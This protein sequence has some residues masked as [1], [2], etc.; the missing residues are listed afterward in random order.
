MYAAAVNGKCTH[1]T[2]LILD[3]PF[4]LREGG[5]GY[6]NIWV[7]IISRDLLFD[8]KESEATPKV[9]ASVLFMQDISVL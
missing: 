7:E 9:S 3:L 1:L 4:L 2:G 6:I 5:V 8:G